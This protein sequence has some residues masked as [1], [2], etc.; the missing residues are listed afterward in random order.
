MGPSRLS[1]FELPDFGEARFI[2]AALASVVVCLALFTRFVDQ[3]HFVKLQ[4]IILG[5]YA[6]HSILDDKL[7]DRRQG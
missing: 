2:L 6:A 1:F 4:A 5:L 7:P 3:E